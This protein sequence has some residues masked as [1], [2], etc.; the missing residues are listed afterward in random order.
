MLGVAESIALHLLK[1]WAF[2]LG[3]VAVRTSQQVNCPQLPA[4]TG[5]GETANLKYVV[6]STPLEFKGQ[7]SWEDGRLV[8]TGRYP[9]GVLL[10]FLGCLIGWTSGGVMFLLK[11]ELVGLPF[12]LIGWLFAGGI[13]VHSRWLERQRFSTNVDEVEAALCNEVGPRA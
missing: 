13:M 2:R 5:T 3:P 1:P 8:A 11:G 6:R 12:I 4:A 7:L 10:F 9:M